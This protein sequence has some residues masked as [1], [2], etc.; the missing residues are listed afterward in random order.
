MN[1][2]IKD[3]LGSTRV[4]INTTDLP[5]ALTT[6]DYSAF[7]TILTTP[8]SSAY[9]YT[10]Q[11]WDQTSGL[12]NFRARM[13]DSDLAMFYGVDPAGQFNSPFGYSGNN[14]VIRVDKDGKLAWFVPIIVAAAVQGGF[15]TYQAIKQDQS[16]QMVL[17]SGL[18]G[19][20]L[21]AASAAIGY[22][23]GA[24]AALGGKA[25]GL[26][27]GLTTVASGA[28]GGAASSGFSSAVTGGNFKRGLVSGAISG[29]LGGAFDLGIDKLK[30][31]GTAADIS[32]IAAGGLAGGITEKIMGGNFKR[33]LTNGVIGSAVSYFATD[34]TNHVFQEG[35]QK[36]IETLG[37]SRQDVN[38]MQYV[39][40]D[41]HKYKR[42][43]DPN[44]NEYEQLLELHDQLYR[45]GTT[46]ERL[47]HFDA[48][49]EGSLRFDRIHV[50]QNQFH[51]DVFS[52]VTNPL[53][54]LLWDQGYQNTRFG[55]Q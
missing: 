42:N 28:V 43:Y 26:S 12:H 45:K 6:H 46:T 35:D 20:A 10:G 37:L 52:A 44:K 3:H 25:I 50:R 49:V 15:N 8:S 51:Y 18:K 7:G 11:E 2:V 4:M 32:K 39:T 34:L 24:W 38:D 5:Y 29:G 13:Y 53:L 41:W 30:L 33:G 40:D 36:V 21:G 14:P 19:A 16:W 48:G 31:G 55:G 27:A 54:H 47:S 17:A 1:Y 23:F 22:Q 9:L